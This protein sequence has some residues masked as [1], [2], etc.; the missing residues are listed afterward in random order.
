MNALVQPNPSFADVVDDLMTY[1][2]TREAIEDPNELAEFD[3][4]Y[5][6]RTEAALMKKTAGVQF[7]LE[8]LDTWEADCRKQAKALYER[9]AQ[10]EDRRDRIKG[11]IVD[12][13]EK[14]GLNKVECA[15]GGFRLHPSKGVEITDAEKVPE[16]F[17]R[18]E[19][20]L[21]G[22]TLDILNGLMPEPVKARFDDFKLADIKKVIDAGGE[23]PGAKVKPK[24]SAVL[25]KP[26][27][28]KEAAGA[29]ATA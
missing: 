27:A 29:V 26:K 12:V 9:A 23:V 3:A 13:L 14:A 5:K 2:D 17:R 20:T 19:A 15:T 18:Y 11:Y 16:R 7:V 22:D 6:K 10:L 4:E 21:D 25:I 1:L 8:Q 28:S 24:N